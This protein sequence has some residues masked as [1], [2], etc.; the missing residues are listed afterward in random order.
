MK[1]VGVA[2][3][4][5]LWETLCDP[6]TVFEEVAVAV[7]ELVMDAEADSVIDVV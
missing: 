7:A 5:T 1:V 6:L 4:E 2:V 3:T